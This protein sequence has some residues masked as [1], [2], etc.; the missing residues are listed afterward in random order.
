MGYGMGVVIAVL[1]AELVLWATW[2]RYYFAYGIPLF[3]K[4]VECLLAPSADEV[5]AGL[6]ASF[7]NRLFPSLAFKK[8]GVGRWAFR[9]VLL[10]FTLFT[11][12]SIMRGTLV[13]DAAASRISIIGW[14]MVWPV[15]LAGGFL[16]LVPGAAE[17]LIVA[18]VVFLLYVVQ[19]SRFRKVAHYVEQETKRAPPRKAAVAPVGPDMPPGV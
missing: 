7:R 19:W 11:Y 10:Q 13:H 16:F 14:L 18:A 5:M 15:L 8:I 9:E 12:T 3:I 1:V 2:N 4:R 17:F 6:H